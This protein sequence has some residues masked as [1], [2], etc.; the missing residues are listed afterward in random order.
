MEPKQS[1][2]PQIPSDTTEQYSYASAIRQLQ[3]CGHI[4]LLYLQSL[5]YADVE[6]LFEEIKRWLIYG[7]DINFIHDLKK[8]KTERRRSL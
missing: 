2:V 6:C 8:L 3:D 5:S 1:S 4:S 7:R